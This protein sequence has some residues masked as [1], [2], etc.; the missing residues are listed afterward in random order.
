MK[1][2]ISHDQSTIDPSA[3][4]SEAEFAKVQKQ[5]ETEYERAIRAEYPNAEID[6]DHNLSTT[7]SV[8]VTGM[9]LDDPDDV[10]SDIQRICEGVFETGLF[11]L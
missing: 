6:F 2:T 3:T 7:Y 4:Y 10:I 9:G 1:I 5:L 11:W 8:K